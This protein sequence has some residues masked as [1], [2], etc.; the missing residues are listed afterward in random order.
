[1]IGR[2][3]F[4]EQPVLILIALLFLFYQNWSFC[5]ALNDEGLALLRIREKMESDPFGAL[6]GWVDNDGVDDPCFW[7]GVKCSNGNVVALSLKDLCLK[8]TLAP[9]FGNLVH[10]KSIILRNNSFH[11]YIPNKIRELKELEVFDLGYNNF[12]GPLLHDLGNITS[13]A[14]L[15]LDHNDLL[16]STS[17]EIDE[18]KKISEAQV[19][20]NEFSSVIERSPLAKSSISWNIPHFTARRFLKSP[21]IDFGMLKPPPIPLSQS[22]PSPSPSTNTTVT[23]PAENPSVSAKEHKSN[24]HLALILSTTIGVPVLLLFI[25]AGFLFCKG[26]KIASVRPWTTGL[27]GQLQ[28]VFVTGVPKLKRSELEA[29]C[30]DFSNVIGSSI[31]GTLYKG[32]LSN[33]VEIAVASVAIGSAMEWSKNL[34]TQFRNKIDSLSKVNHKNFGNLLGFCEEDEPFTRMLVFEYAPNGTLFEHLHIQEA[35]HLDWGMRMRVIM[36]MAY[37]LDYMHNLTPPI[38]HKSLTSSSV[39]LTDDYAA[40][41]SDFSFWSNI[42]SAEM[43][44]N[45]ENNV[46]DFGVILFEIITGR[47]PYSAGGPLEDW[48]SDFLKGGKKPL[49][50]MVDPT[51]QSFEAEQ[52]EQ[53]GEVIRSCVFHEPRLR[54][55]MRQVASRLR[56]ITNIRPDGAVPRLSPLWWAELEILTTEAS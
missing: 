33:G 17:P 10:I 20:E 4:G 49:G 23:S 32:T 16:D 29:A 50:E 27:S 21:V 5:Y 7:Y 51:L 25:V 1:M 30:E 38:S 19:D 2:W 31:G 56:E 40:K 52:V 11:G 53:I 55:K 42:A 8:G 13:L 14:M 44:A 34:E 22:P 9:D 47:L 46:Y 54:P 41:V 3:R 28:K 6:S 15:L 12:S 45:P 24:D 48:A 36:G 35:E 37:C 18:L 26:S 39:N 43:E